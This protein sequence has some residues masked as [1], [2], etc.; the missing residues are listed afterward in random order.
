MLSADSGL[1][2][3]AWMQSTRPRRQ[4]GHA[5]VPTGCLLHRSTANEET[6][7]LG[8]L[9]ERENVEHMSYGDGL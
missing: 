6:V 4:H 5:L 7:A 3:V 8:S 2:G 9:D 1:H